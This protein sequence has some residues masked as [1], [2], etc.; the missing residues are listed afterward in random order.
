MEAVLD[1]LLGLFQRTF[2]R[3]LLNKVYS[4]LRKGNF[5]IEVEGPLE[6]NSVALQPVNLDEPLTLG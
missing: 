4:H 2:S 1:F 6:L 3:L 5:C